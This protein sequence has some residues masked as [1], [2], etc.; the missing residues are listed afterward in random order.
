MLTSGP[1]SHARNNERL[2]PL[3]VVLSGP[4]PALVYRQW[5][6]A[7][8]HGCGV[9]VRADL[10]GHI[11]LASLANL[12]RRAPLP[13]L[14][15]DRG[16]TLKRRLTL[17]CR[18]LSPDFLDCEFPHGDYP[19]AVARRSNI[20]TVVSYHD[21]EG[22]PADLPKLL[23]GMQAFCC[24]ASAYKIAATASAPVDA[25]RFVRFC[26]DHKSPRHL[27][28]CMGEE[29][30]YTRLLGTRTG[31]RTQFAAHPPETACA[32]GQFSLRTLL[33]TYRLASCSPKTPLLGLIGD[34][35]AQ[36]IGHKVHNRVFAALGIDAL[37]VKIPLR[38][39][40][41]ADFF[42]C[43]QKL[44]IKGLSVTMPLKEA[45]LPFMSSL[46]ADAAAAGAVNTIL[47]ENG[48]PIGHQTDGVG[49]VQAL[50]AVACIK[51]KYALVLGAGGAGKSIAHALIGQGARR[52]TLMNRTPERAAAAAALLDCDW[53]PLSQLE[54]AL[55]TRCDILIQATSQSMQ[56]VTP[57]SA[58]MLDPRTVVMDAAIQGPA[59]PL[60]REAQAAG[61]PTVDGKAL[62]MAQAALQLS[63]WWKIA[64]ELAYRHVVDATLS[65]CG[66]SEP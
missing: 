29:V 30:G 58:D 25:L 35:I 9:E 23:Q 26:A 47:F 46:S 28:F 65:E 8:A 24:D 43:S 53:L 48:L 14:L 11:P 36:S 4:S 66:N 51:D 57:V 10:L 33:D 44:P 52:V 49:A 16:Q 38:A 32:P 22:V 63:L 64:P 50:S 19:L 21:F 59:T 15:T 6:Q 54:M 55:R 2:P 39:A 62:Y 20:R 41:L 34:P 60:L 3:F 45:V 56:G 37:Y 31:C 7:K 17:Y 27:F 12:K 42:D 5:M 40:N 61:C 18:V 13:L 1:K